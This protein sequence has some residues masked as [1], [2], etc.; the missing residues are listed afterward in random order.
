MIIQALNPTSQGTYPVNLYYVQETKAGRPAMKRTPGLIENHSF[1][2]LHPI[3]E[4]LVMGNYLY[5]IVG[6]SLH[7]RLKDTTAWLNLGTLTS[8]TG[9][10]WMKGNGSQVMIV[11]SGMCWVYDALAGT[12]EQ[13]SDPDLF[14]ASC[15]AYHDG[16][17]LIA[18]QNSDEWQ[19]DR[20]H[21][22]MTSPYDVSDCFDALDYEA[23]KKAPGNIAGIVSALGQVWILKEWSYQD[24][25]NAGGSGFPFSPISGANGDV[26]LSAAHSMVE[27]DNSLMWL[28]DKYMVRRAF[29]YNLAQVV[30]T[31]RMAEEF[32]QFTHVSD[33]RA[34]SFNWHGNVFY[35]LTFP[36]ENVTY[37]YN[38][39]TSIQRTKDLKADV[40]WHKWASFPNNGRH[41]SNCYAY[42][43]GKHLVGDFLNGTL[44]EL[45]GHHD[46]NH[47]IR[48]VLTYPIVGDGGRRVRHSSFTQ[49]MKNGVGLIKNATEYLEQTDSEMIETV[50]GEGLNLS[51]AG[52]NAGETPKCFLQYSDDGGESWS[53]EAWADIGAIGDRYLM[54]RWRRLGSTKQHGRIYRTVVTDP[55]DI[56]I[57]NAEVV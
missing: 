35:A 30:S 10:C 36:R 51:A 18:G 6:K 27:L 15:L 31:P 8:Y 23:S 50:S 1:G 45:G 47:E 46:D 32:Q 14:T 38:C 49:H 42:F 48:S 2:V 37:V 56:E 53:A 39:T 12:L 16:Y 3:R 28:D 34:Y 40:F 24:Y 43:E 5:V 22:V 57:Y 44:Y 17:F 9:D 19:C 55:V 20:G 54:S 29:S 26:G 11:D 7:R 41:R 4:M 52:I 33:A 21:I 13:V 25:Y